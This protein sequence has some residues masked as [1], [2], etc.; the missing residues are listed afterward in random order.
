MVTGIDGQTRSARIKVGNNL[1]NRQT[2]KLPVLEVKRD[3]TF[4]IW[5]KSKETHLNVIKDK[6]QEIVNYRKGKSSKLGP[7]H[8]AHP[9]NNNI[10]SRSV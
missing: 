4:P 5:G 10:H 2:A 1:V 6:A 9:Y 8:G 7:Y 3:Q